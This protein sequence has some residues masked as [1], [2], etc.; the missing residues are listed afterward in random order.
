[1]VIVKVGIGYS[2]VGPFSFVKCLE[3]T[4]ENLFSPV[5]VEALESTTVVFLLLLHAEK[6][7]TLYLLTRVFFHIILFQC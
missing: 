6:N 1:M 2:D 5:R 4:R 7:E 3:R